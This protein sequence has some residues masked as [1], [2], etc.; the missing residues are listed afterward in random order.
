M[1][2]L[3]LRFEYPDAKTAETV[4]QSLDP[5][6]GGYV[7]SRLEGSI[8][9]FRMEAENAGSLRNTADDLLACIKIAEE[10]IGIGSR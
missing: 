7:E 8:L 4:M 10:T 2:S 1:L 9:V 5:D 3:E 6:N